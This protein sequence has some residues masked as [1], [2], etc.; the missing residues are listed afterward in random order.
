MKTVSELRKSGYKV[1]V[2]HVRQTRNPAIIDGNADYLLSRYEHDLAHSEGR[3]FYAS[4]FGESVVPNGGFTV[5]EITTPD[6]K[7]LKGKFNFGKRRFER[8]I[9]VKAALGRAYAQ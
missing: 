6:G 3:L 1:R 5:V 9:G 2:T 7:T 8:K 4:P